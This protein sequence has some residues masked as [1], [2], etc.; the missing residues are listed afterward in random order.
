MS[1]IKDLSKIKDSEITLED[2][3]RAEE[4]IARANKL[5][6]RATIKENHYWHGWGYGSV[7]VPYQ[8]Y[9][10]TN[11]TGPSTN[12]IAG[13]TGSFSGGTYVL[14]PNTSL[15]EAVAKILS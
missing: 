13:G 1:L 11:L 4:I 3:K 6:G 2:V 5:L 14:N 7:T 12:A 15:T 10:Y 8:P 9:Y